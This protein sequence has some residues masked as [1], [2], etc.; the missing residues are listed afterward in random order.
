MDNLISVGITAS[1]ILIGLLA[2]G[3]MISRL[4]KRASKETAFVRTGLGG[5]KVIMNGGAL[6]FPVLHETISVNMNTLRL[7]VRRDNQQALITNDRMRVDVVA[8]FYVRVKPVIESIS[9][10]AQTLGGRTMQPEN[11]KELIEGKFV[12]ALRSVASEMTMKE[13]HEKRS[14]FVQKVQQAVNED[15]NKNGLEL[16]SVSLTGLDQTDKSYFNKDNAFDAEGLTKLTEEI[17]ARRKTRNDIEQETRVQIETK[18][19]ETE[20]QSLQ[21]ARDTEYARLE[22]E[23]EL[24]IRRAQQTAEIA[25]QQ[26][27]RQQEAEQAQI[28]AQQEIQKSQILSDRAIETEKID[29]DKTIQLSEQDRDIAIAEKSEE[30]SKAQA[31]ADEARALSAEA[32]QKVETARA[33]EIAEREKKIQLIQAAQQAEQDAIAI[34]VAA[35]AELKAA[36]NRAEAAKQDATGKAESE[37]LLADAAK[38]RYEVD[39]EGKRALNEAQNLLDQAQIDM[40][41]KLKTIENLKDIIAQSVKPMENIDGIKIVQVDGLTGKGSGTASNTSS[42]SLADSVV[43]AALSYRAQAPLLDNLMKSIGI[44]GSN[45]DGLTKAASDILS[46]TVPLADAVV[47]IEPDPTPQTTTPSK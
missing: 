47:N 25:Q 37:K 5:E 39:A 19:L 6:V 20:K 26:A 30:Q 10:A 34:T 46:P 14:E 2:I 3:L 8:D 29:K 45:A 40:Q 36:T 27:E 13:L 22:Q 11:L 35:E 43:N 16:E 31:K 18:N 15:L 1:A 38:V 21:I 24:E 12:D 28:T 7:A 41:V 32:E 9:N 44:D 42:G 17:E 23:R 33:S 4:Y